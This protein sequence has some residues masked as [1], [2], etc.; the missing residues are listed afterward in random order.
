[1][2]Q[3]ILSTISQ[4]LFSFE[5]IFPFLLFKNSDLDINSLTT[6]DKATLNPRMLEV[7]S[8]RLCKRN[9]PAKIHRW[10]IFSHLNGL[11]LTAHSI[12]DHK[13]KQIVINFH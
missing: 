7:P 3:C 5:F 8:S 10:S 13:Y 4:K 12:F 6:K 1:M 11:L 9:L 2:G